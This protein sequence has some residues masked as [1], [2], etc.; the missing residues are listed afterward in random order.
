MIVVHLINLELHLAVLSSFE[1][2]KCDPDGVSGF[3]PLWCRQSVPDRNVCEA[4]VV[5]T[6]LGSSTYTTRVSTMIRTDVLGESCGLGSAD[7][8]ARALFDPVM[9]EAEVLG[10]GIAAQCAS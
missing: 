8:R 6:P 2:K 3:P 7:K 1:V 5:I 4:A 9:N 10:D